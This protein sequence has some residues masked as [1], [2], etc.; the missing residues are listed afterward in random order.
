[1]SQVV[2]AGDTSGTITLQAPAVSGSNVL[3]LP[4]NTGTVLTTTSTFGGTGP[5]FAAYTSVD[6][7][8]TNVTYTKVTFN[9]EY[10]DTNS[11]FASSR[12]TPTVAGYYQINTSFVYICTF[13]T[14]TVC[15]LYK[16][17]ASLTY[18]NQYGTT[19]NNASSIGLSTI[20]YA[21]GTTD[22][23]EI[24]CYINATGTLYVQQGQQ[25]YFNAA[26]IRSA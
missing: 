20:V 23:F 14:Q 21:N 4:A 24:Y 3:T 1:M 19:A 15:S 8:M 25:A 7:T 13:A 22:Y 6:V 18:T 26:M 5:A 9:I 10:F 12:F 17:G 11:N 2:I 16:N